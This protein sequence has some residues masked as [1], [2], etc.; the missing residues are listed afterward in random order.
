[1]LK[2]WLLELKIIVSKY[3]YSSE[4]NNNQP[5]PS[6]QYNRAC[7]LNFRNVWTRGSVEFRYHNGSLNFDKIVSWIV[8][9][10]AIIIQSKMPIAF[11]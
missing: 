4:I 8:F 6:V 1:M 9:T 7:G 11:K 3:R 10:Q 5:S 2:K